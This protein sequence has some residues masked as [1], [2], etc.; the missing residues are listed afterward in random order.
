MSV[1]DATPAQRTMLVGALQAAAPSLAA[2]DERGPAHGRGETVAR[3]P[4]VA[5]V[6]G[7]LWVALSPGSVPGLVQPDD[8]QMM[9][10]P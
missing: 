6:A 4:S 2:W 5:L 7:G 9:M 8:A 1:R 10:Q 3:L